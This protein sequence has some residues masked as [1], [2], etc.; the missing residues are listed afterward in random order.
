MFYTFVLLFG[1]FWGSVD[2]LAFFV[3]V[4]VCFRL[5]LC[6]WPVFSCFLFSCGSC[7]F[8]CVLSV[9]CFT[10]LFCVVGGWVGFVLLFVSFV[11]F[12]GFGVGCLVGVLDLLACLFVFLCFGVSVFWCF[13]V[14]VVVI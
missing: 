5:Y 4:L 12:W 7:T 6:W 13:C 3:Y 2:L 10:C 11:L 1:Y 14:V 8:G 9:F